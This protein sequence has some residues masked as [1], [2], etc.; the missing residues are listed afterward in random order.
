[1]HGGDGFLT[2]LAVL[3][4]MLAVSAYWFRRACA[5]RKHLRNL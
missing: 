5:E 3:L 4:W 2:F 1:V